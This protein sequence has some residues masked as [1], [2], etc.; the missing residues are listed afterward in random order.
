MLSNY[1]C[2]LDIGSSKIAGIAA[3]IKRKRIANIFFETVPS[4]GIKRG[5]IVDSID[6]SNSISHILKS[7]KIKSSINIKFI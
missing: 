7:L 6:L 4:K 2:A 3:D 1:I 5:A